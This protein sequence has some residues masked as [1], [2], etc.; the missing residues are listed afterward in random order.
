MSRPSPRPLVPDGRLA[1]VSMKAS[2]PVAYAARQSFGGR[3]V[4][5]A[6]TATAITGGSGWGADE[7][8]CGTFAELEACTSGL[9]PASVTCSR[10]LSVAEREHITIGDPR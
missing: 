3:A 7:P 6:V 9:F 4:V 10:C 5:H 2:S 8:L 1:A